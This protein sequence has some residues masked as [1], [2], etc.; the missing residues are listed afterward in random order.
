MTK[1]VQQCCRNK[2]ISQD[3]PRKF[4]EEK[5]EEPIN[6]GREV[7]REISTASDI[8]LVLQGK[9]KKF[10]SGSGHMMANDAVQEGI[11]RGIGLVEGTN[12]QNITSED[13]MRYYTYPL[14]LSC[15]GV[16]LNFALIL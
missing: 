7:A 16:S 12:D 5:E 3:W 13:Y 15:N 2:E 10:S 8:L 6:S 11:D 1:K 14:H 9:F 4:R